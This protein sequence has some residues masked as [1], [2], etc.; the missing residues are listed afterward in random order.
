MG[1]GQQRPGA[2]VERRGQPHEPRF[3]SGL[4]HQPR[5]AVTFDGAPPPYSRIM[6]RRVGNPTHG[7][8]GGR[9]EQSRL[10]PDWGSGVRLGDQLNTGA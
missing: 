8:V 1:L 9:R 6:N 10:L 4:L 5:A 2:L 7:G 3:P